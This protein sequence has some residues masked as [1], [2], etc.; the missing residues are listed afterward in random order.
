MSSPDQAE[1]RSTRTRVSPKPAAW[2]GVWIASGAFALG[3]VLAIDRFGWIGGLLGWW[4]AAIAAAV[5]GAAVT[6]MLTRLAASLSILLSRFYGA[7]RRLR[8]PRARSAADSIVERSVA[9]ATPA[10]DTTSRG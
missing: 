1:V 2:I 5:A 10:C 3:W 9:T 4:P 7:R 6:I 8:P